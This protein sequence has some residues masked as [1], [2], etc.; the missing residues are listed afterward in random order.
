MTPNEFLMRGE[1]PNAR[2]GVLLIHGLSGT[3]AEMRV[4]ARGLNNAGFTVFSVQ[5]AGH[6]GTMEDL[7]NSTWAQWLE[8]AREGLDWLGAQVDRVFVGGLSMGSVLSLALAEE[9]PA[10]VAGVLALSTTFRHDGWSMPVY[11]RLSFLIPFLRSLGLCRDR[12]FM[13]LPPYGIK[14]EGLRN[15]VVGQ[16]HG[17]DSAAA[18]LPGNPWWSVAEL[19]ALSSHVRR[20][21]DRVRSPC[22][23]IH[24]RH[25]DIASLSN[26]L[27]IQRRVRLA[28]VELL[29]L[30]DCY[31]MITIDRE[32]RT[33]IARCIEFMT[34]IAP[35]AAADARHEDLPALAEVA[36]SPA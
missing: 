25:D 2:T 10:Q 21:L 34:R 33:V 9:R 12:Q 18:G 23:V 20:R 11:S 26:A 27:D 30:D 8:S 24:A 1:G 19:Q 6:C 36:G 5:L 14:D 3:P 17:G 35:P 22:L 32:R 13:E 7:L 16:M 15:R 31:H 29:L 4:L 28:P